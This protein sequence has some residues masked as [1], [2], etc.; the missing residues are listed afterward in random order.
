MNKHWSVD[1]KELVKNPE[2]HTIWKLEQRINWG[3]GEKIMSKVDLLKFWDRLD[4]DPWKR[5][6][7]ALALFA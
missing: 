2:A 6:A 7:L 1:E 3:I 5:K 4:I